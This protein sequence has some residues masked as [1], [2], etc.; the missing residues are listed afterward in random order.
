MWLSFVELLKSIRLVFFGYEGGSTSYVQAG[1][2]S[3]INV[4]SIAGLRVGLYYWHNSMTAHAYAAIKWVVRGMTKA[5]MEFA[6]YNVRINSIHPGPIETSML[7]EDVKAKE[8]MAADIPM[9][10]L[11]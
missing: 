4:S 1:S 7:G 5:A 2:G 8:K 6:P 11:G 10:R 3:I 9:K